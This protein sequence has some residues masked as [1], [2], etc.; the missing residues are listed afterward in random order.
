MPD[1]MPAKAF[2]AGVAAIAI[3]AFTALAKA[4]NIVENHCYTG[5][6]GFI[7]MPLLGGA[8][9]G[10]PAHLGVGRPAHPLPSR[11]RIFR[12]LHLAARNCSS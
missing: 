1:R 12:L 2:V 4:D 3:A 7:G 9:Y 6:F 11:G 10:D 8:S 5:H